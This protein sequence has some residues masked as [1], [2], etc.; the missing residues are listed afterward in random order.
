MTPLVQKLEIST[1][2]APLGLRFHDTASGEF[3]RDGLNVSVY[4]PNK[5]ES[6]VQAIA[7]RTG[8][9]VLHHATGLKAL[10]VGMGDA[11][12]WNNLPPR[13]D[14]VIEVSD[15][16]RRFQQFHFTAQLP[17]SGIYQWLSPL[18]TSPPSALNSVP[19]Y[20]SPTRSAPGGMAVI[21]ADLWDNRR[22][23]PAQWVVLEGYIEDELIVRGI[24]DEAG[25]VALIFPWPAPQRF[26]INSPPSPPVTS[27]PTVSGPPLMTQEWRVR[28]RA[29]YAPTAQTL[30][31]P[32][33]IETKPVSPDLRFTL[34]QPEATIWADEAATQPLAEVSLHYGREQVLR[35][36]STTSPPSLRSSVLFI[37]AAV[38]PP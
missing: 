31:P 17:V 8:V 22:D 5:S 27:P 32:V 13:K 20:S 16:Q 21:R 12:Y 35:S 11:N 30:S 7:N 28:L 33:P 15:E 29:L 34:S 4:P 38:S 10:E 14:F 25:K 9:Y 36:T 2:V 3:V 19:L 1:R 18:P 26:A 23:L 6:R 24:A 37:T